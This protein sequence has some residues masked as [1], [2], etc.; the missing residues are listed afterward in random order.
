MGAFPSNRD[1]K[2][3]G[4]RHGGAREHHKGPRGCP[5]LIVHAVD[6]I[7][8]EALKEAVREH[9]FRAP[10][11]F[12]SGLKNKVHGPGKVTVLREPLCRAQKHRHMPVVP[13][14][15]H[16]A[17]ILRGVGAARFFGKR[18]RIHVGSQADCAPFALRAL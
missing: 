18:Q 14:G 7:A 10:A 11:A 13:A 9:C 16:C 17:F 2:E 8:R 15:V 3:V 1:F 6:L 4:A 5:G 12:F